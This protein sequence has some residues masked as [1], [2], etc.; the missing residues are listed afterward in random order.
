M[1]PGRD[2]LGRAA[3]GP[4]LIYTI[5]IFGPGQNECDPNWAQR[6]FDLARAYK[7]AS[8]KQDDSSFQAREALLDHALAEP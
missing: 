8:P 2:R 3:W 4:K 6:L 5:W 7:W 1:I